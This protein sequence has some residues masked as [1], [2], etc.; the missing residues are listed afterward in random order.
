MLPDGIL[1]HCDCNTYKLKLFWFCVYSCFWVGFLTAYQLPSISC[2]QHIIITSR[3]W[4]YQ[5][6]GILIYVLWVL[7]FRSHFPYRWWRTQQ[8]HSPTIPCRICADK[9]Q[10]T[11]FHSIGHDTRTYYTNY[12]LTARRRHWEGVWIKCRN[13]LRVWFYCQTHFPS[14]VLFSIRENLTCCCNKIKCGS[15]KLVNITNFWAMREYMFLY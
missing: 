11:A 13:T 8:H 14:F 4:V 15:I 6:D 3:K 1:I 7:C 12:R 5:N 9:R 2:M 10:P